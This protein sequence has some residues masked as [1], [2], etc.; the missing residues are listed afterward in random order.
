[1]RNGR[2]VVKFHG[3]PRL[4]GYDYSREGRY[5]V[6]TSCYKRIQRFGRVTSK[7]MCL[8]AMGEFVEKAILEI[9]LRY[10]GVAVPI[11]VV[12]PDHVHLIVTI[13]SEASCSLTRIIGT[14]K[15]VA[16]HECLNWC[17]ANNERMGGILWQRSFHERIIRDE[18]EYGR[19]S[20]YI[21]DNPAKWYEKYGAS[22]Y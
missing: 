19:I 14:F 4:K 2:K 11:W 12:M 16:Y 6:T 21:R 10:E 17:K 5:F 9:P 1:M 22:P 18:A 15:S 20:R 7:G 8:N 3:T 13:G